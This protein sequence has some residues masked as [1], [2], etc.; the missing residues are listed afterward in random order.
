MLA[1]PDA[2]ELA[3]RLQALFSV[4]ERDRA[5]KQRLELLVAVEPW[6]GAEDRIE[7]AAAW[8]GKVGTPPPDVRVRLLLDRGVQIQIGR[9][10]EKSHS[11]AD[12]LELRGHVGRRVLP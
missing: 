12:S 11:N 9:G 8:I 6:R 5:S 4:V 3:V 10:G 2:F 7:D 1:N